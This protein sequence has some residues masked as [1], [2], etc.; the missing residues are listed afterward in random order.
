MIPRYANTALEQALIRCS[1]DLLELA[2][3]KRPGDDVRTLRVA[4]RS[5]RCA[6]YFVKFDV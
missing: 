3:R 2:E 6:A 4:G 1:L 5:T